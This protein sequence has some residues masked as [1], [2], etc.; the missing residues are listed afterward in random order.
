MVGEESHILPGVKPGATLSSGE[1]FPAWLYRA[2]SI[3]GSPVAAQQCQQGES[4]VPTYGSLVSKEP[5]IVGRAQS[6]EA[7]AFSY[8]SS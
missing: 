1:H 4:H 7:C 2:G 3:G 8:P 5:D 6:S